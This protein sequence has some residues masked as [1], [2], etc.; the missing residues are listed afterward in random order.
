MSD[1]EPGEVRAVPIDALRERYRRYRLPD[2][3]AE[4]ALARSDLAALHG[5]LRV[6]LHAHPLQELA[7]EHGSAISTVDGLKITVSKLRFDPD[8]L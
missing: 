7:Q 8:K 1:W 5:V 6:V 4:A 3:E 2:A